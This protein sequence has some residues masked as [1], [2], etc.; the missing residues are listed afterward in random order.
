[1][2]DRIRYDRDATLQ[3]ARLEETLNRDGTGYGVTA[4]GGLTPLTTV[5]VS[6]NSCTTASSSRPCATAHSFRVMPG[7][8][9]K[10]RALIKGSA[11]V[12][13]RKF[14]PRSSLIPEFAG[15]VSQLALSYTL[16]GAT[17]FGVT[18]DRDV[19]YSYAVLTPYYIDNSPGVFIR[20]ALGGKFDLVVNAAR[21]QYSYRDLEVQTLVAEEPRVDTTDNYGAN[22]GYRL[23]QN[24][25]VGFGASYYRRTSTRETL[26]LQRLRAGMVVNYGF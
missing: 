7:V 25:R 4:R 3:G 21:H 6:T 19:T 8:E 9:F 20:R 12:G 15:L 1:M 26:R 16:L 17:T 11:Y 23:K 24:T 22:L 10:P 2:R 5:A 14:T 13:Y 18:F